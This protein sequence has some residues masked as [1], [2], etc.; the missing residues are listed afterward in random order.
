[1]LPGW[2]LVHG[3]QEAMYRDEV[4]HLEDWCRVN[5]L[6]LNVDKTKEMIIDFRKSQTEH[7]PLSIS[8]RTVER[9]EN[10]KFL[11]VQISQDLSWNKNTSYITKRAQQRLYFLRKLKQ[12]SL[13]PSILTTFYR[14]VVESILTYCISTWYS[15]CSMSD[16]KALQRIIRGAER[17]IGVSLPSIEELFQ[18]RCKKRALTIVN[19]LL[20]PLNKL[21]ELL[22]SGKRFRSIKGRTN[23]LI[24]NFIPQAVRMLNC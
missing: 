17:V 2:R 13:P 9:V 22:P 20:H 23:R 18:S 11:G 24:N 21:F 14:G 12:T 4:Q 19:D 1:M 10:I 8:G 6:L 5:N 7:A 16:K 3:S 15:S